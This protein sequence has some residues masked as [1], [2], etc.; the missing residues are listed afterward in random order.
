LKGEKKKLK[1]IPGAPPRLIMPPAGCRFEPRCKYAL[2]KCKTIDPQ[3]IAKDGHL[4]ACH[5]I[6]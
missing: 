5:L 1:S 4:V 3:V 2:E 6:N